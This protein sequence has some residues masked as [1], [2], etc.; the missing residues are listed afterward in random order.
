VRISAITMDMSASE[1]FDADL[2]QPFVFHWPLTNYINFWKE[3]FISFK[4]L[5]CRLRS[6]HCIETTGTVVLA[7]P[8]RMDSIKNCWS[9]CIRS[10]TH[11][12]SV[13]TRNR[14]FLLNIYHTVRSGHVGS[15]YVRLR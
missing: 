6:I 11:H 14:Y 5:K 15:S 10:R 3:Y 9:F 12:I 7:Q 4:L 1:D 2:F 8:L 13:L